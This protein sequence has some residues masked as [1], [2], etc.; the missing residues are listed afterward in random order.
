[1]LLTLYF[2]CALGFAFFTVTEWLRLEGNS[3]GHL[4]QLLSRHGH[5][6]QGHLEHIQMLRGFFVCFVFFILKGT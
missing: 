2:F 3:G 4:V 6:E 5:P 1:M